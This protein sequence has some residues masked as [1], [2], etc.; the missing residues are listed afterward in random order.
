MSNYLLS[1]RKNR[2]ILEKWLNPGLGA[3]NVQDESK[4]SC[5]VKTKQ[6]MRTRVMT[7]DLGVNSNKIPLTKDNE[8]LVRLLTSVGWNTLNMLKSMTSV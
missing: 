2:G 3:G 5:P 4:M 7:K 6:A 1:L 8:L